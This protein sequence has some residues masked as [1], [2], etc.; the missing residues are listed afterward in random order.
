VE[1]YNSRISM[2]S[3]NEKIQVCN[4]DSE[5]PVV[6]NNKKIKRKK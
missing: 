3:R 2:A 6:N 4:S 5:E 1:G